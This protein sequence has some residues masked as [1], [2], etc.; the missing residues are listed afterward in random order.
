MP[1]KKNAKKRSYLYNPE[2]VT[3]F[4]LR[5]TSQ[6][7]SKAEFKANF[8]R[9]LNVGAAKTSAEKVAL[10]D[11]P[12]LPQDLITTSVLDFF[13]SVSTTSNSCGRCL[14][15][16]SCSKCAI[17]T[18]SSFAF[19]SRSQLLDRSRMLPRHAASSQKL[20]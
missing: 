3:E 6:N 16:S 14:A 8:C 18:R 13:V 19:D 7:E 17:S 9:F 12:S 2:F 11:L 1:P 15:R 5:A 4:G 20:G 10:A